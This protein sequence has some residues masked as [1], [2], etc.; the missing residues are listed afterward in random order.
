METVLEAKDLVKVYTRGKSKVRALRGV[1]LR[2]RKGEFVGIM[3]PSGCGKSTLLYILGALDRPT[4]GTVIWNGK[5]LT[6][7]GDVELSSFRNR[8][9]GFVFQSYNLLPDKKAWENVAL[10]LVYAGVNARERRER[11]YNLLSAVGLADR[12]DHYPSE[13]SGGE[14][15]RV[16]I[17]RALANNPSLILADEPTGNL[18]SE[19]SK[20]VLDLLSSL[21]RESGLTVLMVTHNPALKEHCHRIVTMR[22]GMLLD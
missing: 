16:A 8:Y 3:G 11:A 20:Q 18:D 2:V 5:D 19:S 1:S 22:D 12:A 14:E 21:N 10:P 6:G 4:S 13:L 17:A 15:Q 9:A 7:L